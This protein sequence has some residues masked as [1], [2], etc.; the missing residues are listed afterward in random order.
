[1]SL[2]KWLI[3]TKG[4]ASYLEN[5]REF[6]EY[7][8]R[9]R[10]E[11][12]VEPAYLDKRVVPKSKYE[13][14]LGRFANNAFE[15][16]MRVYRRYRRARGRT[17]RRRLT[18][19][20]DSPPRVRR[21]VTPMRTRSAPRKRVRTS[22]KSYPKPRSILGERIG[23][24]TCKSR[25]TNEI[26]DPNVPSDSLVV[27][28]NLLQ[29]TEGSGEHQRENRT[30]N[31][32]GIELRLRFDAGT[33]LWDAADALTPGCSNQTPIYFHMALVNPKHLKGNEKPSSVDWFRNYDSQRGQDFGDITNIPPKHVIIFN[34]INADLYNIFWHKRWKVRRAA[35][36]NNGRGPEFL[37]RKYIK[38]KRQIRFETTEAT[39]CV[40][41]L[42]L[43]YWWTHKDTGRDLS[44]VNIQTFPSLTYQTIAFFRD[45]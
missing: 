12:L 39:S 23:S 6:I 2:K 9:P 38:I 19:V 13:L 8:V 17:G 11:R 10:L 1:M 16:T 32:R 42:F 18:M 25:T 21:V 41:G 36:F 30:I 43:C 31:L 28:D 15:K 20:L 45:E 35:S 26:A 14:Q 27:S 24:S 37:F 40:D 33:K 5:Q 22:R 44:P 7:A 4:F 3:P 29:I 34:P